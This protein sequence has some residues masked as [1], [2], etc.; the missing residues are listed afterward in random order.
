MQTF[1]SI[2]AENSDRQ[3]NLTAYFFDALNEHP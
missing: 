2:G 3:V 1:G